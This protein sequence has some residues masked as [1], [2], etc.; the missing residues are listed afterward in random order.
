MDASLFDRFARTCGSHLSR[1][2]LSLLAVSLAF[3]FR[4][5]L[6]EEVEVA[7][8]NQ[9]KNNKHTNKGR[10][11]PS[12]FCLNG[13][14]AQASSKKKKRKLLKQGATQGACACTPQCDG[15]SCGG[16]DGC[17][18]TCG[19]GANAVC[20]QGTCRSCTVVCNGTGMQCGAALQGALAAGGTVVACPGRYVGKYKTGLATTLIG[21]GNGDD[22]AVSTI[23]DAQGMGRVLYVNA[24][25]PISLVGVHLTGGD[26]GGV[27]GGGIFMTFGGD[28]TV[29]SC[30]ITA[31]EAT[32][33]GGISTATPLTLTNSRVVG[34]SSSADGG[35]LALFNSTAKMF[36]T[37]ISGNT[38]TG[39]GGGIY[40]QTGTVIFDS[41][42]RVTN[43]TAVNGGGISNFGMGASIQ[44]N[45]VVIADNVPDQCLGGTGC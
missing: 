45:G 18:G 43:N 20:A 15:T 27:S 30:A 10:R 9:N 24:G 41:A 8:K 36:N 21:A 13:Q 6:A 14:N 31:N 29:D 23:L 42:S 32:G 38:T 16:S 25:V 1:R 12:T 35:G 11:K 37:L 5:S 26:A 28:L 39:D 7:A 34:N 44:R 40:N 2:R 4:K 17:G 33:G 3:P 22:P 19:C